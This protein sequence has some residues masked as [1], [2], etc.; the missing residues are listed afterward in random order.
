MAIVCE[1][2]ERQQS[3]PVVLL[4][5]HGDSD[6]LFELLVDVFGLAIRLGVICSGHQ[7]FDSQESIQFAHKLSH[8]LW[9][10]I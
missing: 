7:N 5:T 10:T 2:T 4:F 1:L 8:E 6:I 9:P 3:I